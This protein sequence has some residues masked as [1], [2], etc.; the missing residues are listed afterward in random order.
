LFNLALKLLPARPFKRI[1]GGRAVVEPTT[2]FVVVH[3]TKMV[4]IN[5]VTEEEENL[6]VLSNY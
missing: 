1:T 5:N 4:I 6:I 2:M 3:K